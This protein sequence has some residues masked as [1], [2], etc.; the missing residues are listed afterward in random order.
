MWYV[1]NAHIFE[2]LKAFKMVHKNSGNQNYVVESLSVLVMY[3]WQE[4]DVWDISKVRPR[5]LRIK[6]IS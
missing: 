6:T 1:V 3:V 5:F 2:G 4:F